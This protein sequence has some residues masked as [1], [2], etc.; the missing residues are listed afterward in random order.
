MHERFRLT[1]MLLDN[2]I[3]RRKIRKMFAVDKFI[4]YSHV[5]CIGKVFSSLLNIFLTLSRFCH[6]LQNVPRII[7]VVLCKHFP[8]T[9]QNEGRFFLIFLIK[10]FPLIPFESSLKE[11]KRERGYFHILCFNGVLSF[12]YSCIW[13]RYVLEKS[14]LFNLSK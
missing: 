1:L 3:V 4:G 7:I 9:W 6:F 2:V 5:L 12:S 14:F 11:T 8:T 13:A 10:I